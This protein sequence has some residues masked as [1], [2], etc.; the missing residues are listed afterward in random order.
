M[1]LGDNRKGRQPC[2]GPTGCDNCRMERIQSCEA[3][4]AV[5]EHGAQMDQHMH[6][7]RT[8]DGVMITLCTMKVPNTYEW[9][10]SAKVMV[11]KVRDKGRFLGGES[12]LPRRRRHLTWLWTQNLLD[13]WRGDS[14]FLRNGWNKRPSVNGLVWES[15]K[16]RRVLRTIMGAEKT[17]TCLLLLPSLLL[18]LK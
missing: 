12:E 9:T 11:W 4:G 13:R 17:N 18:L 6:S 5:G 10:E 7:Y 16:M 1:W 14:L 2:R 8:W 3:E 15:V